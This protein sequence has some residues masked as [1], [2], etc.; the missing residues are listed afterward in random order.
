MCVCVCARTRVYWGTPFANAQCCMHPRFDAELWTTSKLDG[1]VTVFEALRDQQVALFNG[2]GLVLGSPELTPVRTGITPG[3]TAPLPL[4]RRRGSNS[5]TRTRLRR[6]VSCT[7]L[8]GG[9]A[10]STE[11]DDGA[12]DREQWSGRSPTGE[13]GHASGCGAGSGAGACERSAHHGVVGSDFVMVGLDGG[14]EVEEL[15]STG[16]GSAPRQRLFLSTGGSKDTPRDAPAIGLPP[17]MEHDGVPGDDD[18]VLDPLQGVGAGDTPPHPPARH[19]QQPLSPPTPASMVAPVVAG[20]ASPSQAPHGVS[21]LSH[22]VVRAPPTSRVS[23]V[24]RAPQHR[25]RGLGPAAREILFR[26]RWLRR[27]TSGLTVDDL[28]RLA[29][30]CRRHARVVSLGGDKH[31][32][33]RRMVEG[34]AGSRLR[35]T[36]WLALVERR[37][38]VV[39]VGSDDTPRGRG[40]SPSPGDERVAPGR[41]PVRGGRFAVGAASGTGGGS[42]SAATTPPADDLGASNVDRYFER[43]YEELRELAEAEA[44]IGAEWAASMEQD[45]LRTYV[46]GHG[47]GECTKALLEPRKTRAR[48]RVLSGDHDATGSS[49]AGSGAPPPSDAHGGA[50]SGTGAGGQGSGYTS[51]WDAAGLTVDSIASLVAEALSPAELAAQADAD[52]RQDADADADDVGSSVHDSQHVGGRSRGASSVSVDSLGVDRETEAKRAKLRRVLGALVMCQSP[53]R[54]IQ[55]L[56]FIARMLLHECDGDEALAFAILAHMFAYVRAFAVRVWVF[57]G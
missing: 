15:N 55:G 54:Y 48:R 46:P 33:R 3:M 52:A 49:G 4:T 43:S 24:L 10:S 29:C 34:A 45:V 31:L 25:H 39:Q 14:G 2:A 8:D 37:A 13:G 5:G 41:A 6:E 28:C 17:V 38:E 19:Q 35:G 57:C 36:M 51:W 42:P 30:V 9:D 53:P 7:P 18:A 23:V 40:S 21:G 44:S 16:H 1:V 12:S 26:R 20:A 32:W 50:G 27:I 22:G 47:F 56:N 11:S